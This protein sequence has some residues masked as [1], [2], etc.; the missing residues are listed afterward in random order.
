LDGITLEGDLVL[1]IKCPAK[2]ADSDLWKAVES[3]EVPE[4]YG[5]QIEHQLM[6]SGAKLAHLWVFDGTLGL[7]R[8]VPARP[9]RWGEIRGAW[10]RFMKF[11]E[12]DTPPPLS[13]RD[14]KVRDD[15]AW[16][17]AATRFLEAKAQSEE[18]AA[19]LDEAK[20][21]LVAL[22]SHPSESGSGVSV[23]Q[24]WKRGSVDYKNVP[25]LKGMDLEPFRGPSR[26]ET[27]VVVS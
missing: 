7:L 18:S 24:Y 10:D 1:E 8:E 13:E 6:V 4:Y 14:T 17:E 15:S 19:A 23:T 9:E 21:A 2:G 5:W 27:R 25:A 20:A 12:S 22:T 3:D 26:L 16:Q 11:I